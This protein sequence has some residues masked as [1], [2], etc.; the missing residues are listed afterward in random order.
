VDELYQY[1]KTAAEAKYERL[2][3]SH[4]KLALMYKDAGCRTRQV[5]TRVDKTETST[6]R[7]RMSSPKP[8][9]CLIESNRASVKGKLVYV[10]E[11]AIRS[12][13]YGSLHDPNFA[14]E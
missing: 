1:A 10:Y 9:K 2:G 8:I 3:S 13:T 11:E 4:P 5:S 7:Q 14:F 12:G 6:Y